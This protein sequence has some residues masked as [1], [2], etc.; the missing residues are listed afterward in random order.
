MIIRL[1]KWVSAPYGVRLDKWA[2]LEYA[3]D[4]QARQIKISDLMSSIRNKDKE[5]TWQ[6]NLASIS[7]A[8]FTTSCSVAMAARKFSFHRKIKLGSTSYS[9][10]ELENTDTASM[11]FA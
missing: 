10:K 2:S 11:L 9:R 3:V 6:G 4:Y 8:L 7:P 5:A 1:D